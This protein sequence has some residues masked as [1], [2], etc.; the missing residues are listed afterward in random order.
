MTAGK[1]NSLGATWK[2]DGDGLTNIK[3]G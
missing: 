2:K 1:K 3:A